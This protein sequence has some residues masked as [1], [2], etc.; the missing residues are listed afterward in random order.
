[1]IYTNELGTNSLNMS[2][3]TKRNRKRVKWTPLSRVPEPLR[4]A[5]LMPGMSTFATTA[6]PASLHKI[7]GVALCWASVFSAPV[8]TTS[9][10]TVD[11]AIQVARIDRDVR[12]TY[13]Y[14]VAIT[15]STERFFTG[16]FK[17]FE[18]HHCSSSTPADPAVLF[19]RAKFKK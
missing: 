7:P 10:I 8:M 3:Q 9:S 2:R 6:L 13:I 11:A 16:P 18:G 15:P 17:L 5:V 12:K 4:S 1:M 19:A 14:F